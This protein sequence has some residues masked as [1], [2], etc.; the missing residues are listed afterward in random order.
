MVLMMVVVV[1]VGRRYETATTTTTASS[2]VGF[3]GR[4]LL[5]L[6][7][8][9]AS[10]RITGRNVVAVVGDVVV[11]SAASIGQLLLLLMVNV[12]NGL[13]CQRRRRWRMMT[14]RTYRGFHFT[15]TWSG[16][17]SRKVN[18]RHFQRH[19]IRTTA[20]PYKNITNENTHTATDS[21]EKI[22]KNTNRKGNAP[23]KFSIQK[24]FK[25]KKEK[26]EKSRF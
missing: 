18:A 11:A 21:Q 3:A 9:V 17:W 16:R 5:L 1:V 22:S 13:R 19:P 14:S 25:R 26:G 2:F 20:Q 23:I 8:I 24:I 6:L 10:R 4:W 7:L 12:V 15:R